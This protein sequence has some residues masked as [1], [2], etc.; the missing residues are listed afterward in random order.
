MQTSDPRDRDGV[1]RTTTF[2]YLL[3]V[4]STL[5]DTLSVSVQFLQHLVPGGTPQ[6]RDA[7]QR[8]GAINTAL[9]VR[10]EMRL[11]EQAL[12]PQVLGIV[13]LERGDSRL[14]P[15]VVYRVTNALTLALGAHF[16]GGPRDTLYGQFAAKDSCYTELL[17]TF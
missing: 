6:L 11:F 12:V 9:S 13:N 17:Y 2:D 3:G 7:Q 8:R 16:F 5:F 4:E 14:S 1:V 15:K 10:L